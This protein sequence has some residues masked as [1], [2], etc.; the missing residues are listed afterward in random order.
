MPFIREPTKHCRRAKI[1]LLAKKSI[2][3]GENCVAIPESMRQYLAIDESGKSFGGNF[4][5]PSG[6]V[7]YG[8]GSLMMGGDQGPQ[9]KVGMLQSLKRQKPPC[10]H[11]SSHPSLVLSIIEY[12]FLEKSGSKRDGLGHLLCSRARMH[13]I[14]HQ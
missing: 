14:L 7:P 5:G 1:K 6:L 4:L 11:N 10:T 9:G 13:D 3:T 12:W 2:E 8:S